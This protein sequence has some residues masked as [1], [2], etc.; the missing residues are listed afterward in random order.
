MIVLSAVGS[1]FDLVSALIGGVPGSSIPLRRKG[2]S[3]AVF[4]LFLM[5]SNTILNAASSK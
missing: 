5:G 1:R 2:T 4:Q 3:L